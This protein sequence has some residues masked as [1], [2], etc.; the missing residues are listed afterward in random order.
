MELSA[1]LKI[2]MNEIKTILN[3]ITITDAF[4]TDILKRLEAFGYVSTSEDAWIISFSIQKVENNIKN[5][6]N[7]TSIPEGLN[8]TAVDMI[9]GEF[10][11]AKKQSGKLNGFNLETAVKQVQTGDTSVTFAVEGS[12]TPEQ[13]LDSLLSYLMNNGKGDFTCYRKIRW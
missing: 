1:E 12:K 8:H 3:S 6:C 11:F 10:L 13:R 4:L 7:V 9:C 5:S 2:V